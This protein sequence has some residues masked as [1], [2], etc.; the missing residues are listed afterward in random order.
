VAADNK[1]LFLTGGVGYAHSTLNVVLPTA[2]GETSLNS[3]GP[4]VG[5]GVE[6]A[7]APHWNLRLEGLT[8]LFDH[9][10]SLFGFTTGA[11]SVNGDFIRQSTV[12]VIRLGANYRY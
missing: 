6:W 4:V 8:Y 11:P 12:N 9:R 1:L 10:K 3:W 2:T 5:S 7:F